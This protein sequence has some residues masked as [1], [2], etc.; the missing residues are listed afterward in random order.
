MDVGRR[1][2]MAPNRD[3]YLGRP[4]GMGYRFAKVRSGSLTLDQP[5]SFAA[6]SAT[7]RPWCRAPANSFSLGIRDPSPAAMVV[8]P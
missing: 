7:K 1:Y 6:V 2:P 4:Y 3:G 5:K 8:A